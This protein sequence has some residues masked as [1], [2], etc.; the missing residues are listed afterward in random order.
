MILSRGRLE[1]FL[2]SGRWAGEVG[3][4]LGK[5]RTGGTL[6]SFRIGEEYLDYLVSL[7]CITVAFR[8]LSNLVNNVPM[9]G[10]S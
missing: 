3:H 2:G 6:R 10:V 5:C 4:V 1:T 8:I 7:T 9:S